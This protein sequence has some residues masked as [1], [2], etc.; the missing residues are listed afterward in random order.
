MGP[1]GHFGDH[2]VYHIR[3]DVPE[4][5][6]P[7]CSLSSHHHSHPMHSFRS[8]PARLH[9]RGSQQDWGGYR[10]GRVVSHVRASIYSH[11]HGNIQ[12]HVRDVS[13]KQAKSCT[14]AQH[15]FAGL[16]FFWGS[17]EGVC[18]ISERAV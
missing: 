13:V 5:Y 4:H 10:V 11:T 3:G 9:F 1:H 7:R 17:D 16:S 12:G 8:V 18:F 2:R 15:V 14:G 6:W